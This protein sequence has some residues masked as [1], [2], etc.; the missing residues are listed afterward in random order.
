MW[1]LSGRQGPLGPEI[2]PDSI[3]IWKTTG[4]FEYF[5]CKLVQRLRLDF[6]I[7][8]QTDVVPKLLFLHGIAQK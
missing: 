3:F 1:N 2:F 7:G 5:L 6:S 4:H 8:Q